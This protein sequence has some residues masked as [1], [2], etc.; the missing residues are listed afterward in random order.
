MGIKLIENG[1][2]NARKMITHT[3][4]LEDVQ[5]GF[6]V[7]LSKDRNRVMKVVIKP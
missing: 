4:A 3:Y 7:M 2:V 1:I 6:D 5:K